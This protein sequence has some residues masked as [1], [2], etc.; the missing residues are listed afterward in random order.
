MILSMML[1]YERTQEEEDGR[2]LGRSDVVGFRV[3]SEI[4]GSPKMCNSPF[5]EVFQDGPFRSHR[6]N[7]C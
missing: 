6:K 1:D 5:P 4:P 7:N 2:R 3:D